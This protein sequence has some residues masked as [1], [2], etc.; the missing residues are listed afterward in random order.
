MALFVLGAAR[1]FRLR[2]AGGTESAKNIAVNGASDEFLTGCSFSRDQYCGM[3]W[4]NPCNA[5]A[6][7]LHC[8]AVAVN[9]RCSFQAYNCILEES[10][11]PQESSA[12]T[13]A[14]YRRSHN[15]RLK[16]VW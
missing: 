11:F 16:R 14:S 13:G 6:N 9:F 3:T 7:V 4:S 12:F 15:F 8:G 10:V 1:G 2:A 5:F